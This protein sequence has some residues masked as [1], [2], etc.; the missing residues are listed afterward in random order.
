MTKCN[1]NHYWSANKTAKFI[2]HSHHE[3]I[4]SDKE[5]SSVEASEW[6]LAKE[7][8]SWQCLY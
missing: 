3:T 1:T 7:E 5:T 2:R 4:S 8:H 6:I